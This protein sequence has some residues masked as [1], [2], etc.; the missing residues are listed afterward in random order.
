MRNIALYIWIA[1]FALSSCKSKNPLPTETWSS[2]CVELAPFEGAYRLTGVCCEFVLLPIIKINEERAFKVKGS[3]HSFTGAGFSNIP[4]EISG[5]LSPDNKTLTLRY[6]VNTQE[7]QFV[8]K[9]G[10]AIIMC[11]CVCY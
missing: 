4:I 5:D 10:K 1:I 9:P 2:G 7:N 3:Y 11:D 8:L 6:S